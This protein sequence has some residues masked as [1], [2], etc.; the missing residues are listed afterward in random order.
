MVER[1]IIGIDASGPSLAAL[2]WGLTRA[3]IADSS[4]ILQHV[5]TGHDG[6]AG[7][8]ALERALDLARD[9]PQGAQ[10][11]TVHGDP[12]RMLVHEAQRGDLLVVGT[13]K[14]GYLRGRVTGTTSVL[15][16][17]LARCATVV[18][19][20][21]TLGHRHGV[22]VGVAAS[23]VCDAAIIEGAVEAQRRGEELSL[24]HAAPDTPGDSE[25]GR[26]LLA[27]A[28]G[29]AARTAPDVT[30]R[31]R[32]S[33]RRAPDALLDAGRNAG[34]LVVGPART[35]AERP[36]VPGD[37]MLEVLLNLTSPAMVAR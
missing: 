10:V 36:G 20:E 12:A 33:H 14:T 18:V 24:V 11:R 17:A 13:H 30:I 9:L 29:L 16:A 25:A 5:V 2:R 4:V 7:E 32:L 28:A 31:R 15:T 21:D 34:L 37:V 35:D 27:A 1:I 8:R 3:A 19:P 23:P 26:T 22:V 6:A